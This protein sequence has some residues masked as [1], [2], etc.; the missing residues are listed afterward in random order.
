MRVSNASPSYFF[1]KQI[2]Q[3]YLLPK[4]VLAA[5]FW[6]QFAME[7]SE[8]LQSDGKWWVLARPQHLAKKSN[9]NRRYS[10]FSTFYYLRPDLSWKSSCK[11]S[12]SLGLA[13]RYRNV[14]RP[15]HLDQKT[16]HKK[17]GKQKRKSSKA[18]LRLFF[19]TQRRRSENCKS[20]HTTSI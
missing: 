12:Q 13:Q 1:D 6:S 4:N 2:H 14:A 3:R 15:Q 19:I 20:K 10:D 5:G 9:W 8:N 7:L 11:S 17:N 16:I 18:L